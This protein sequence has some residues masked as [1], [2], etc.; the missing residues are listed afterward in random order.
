L[1]FISLAK[2]P[3]LF[4]RRKRKGEGGRKEEIEEGRE[5]QCTKGDERRRR[6]GKMTRERGNDTYRR[7][8]TQTKECV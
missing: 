8:E 3:P 5:S 1:K 4:P 7:G 2:R 6:I